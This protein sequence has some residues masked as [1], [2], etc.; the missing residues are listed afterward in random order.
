LFQAL[1][2]AGQGERSFSKLQIKNLQ[3]K[4]DIRV[5]SKILDILVLKTKIQ[6]KSTLKYR[7]RKDL[8][9]SCL[10]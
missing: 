6:L 7:K 2:K 8:G 4:W 5:R 10:D 3:Q 9:E 1:R